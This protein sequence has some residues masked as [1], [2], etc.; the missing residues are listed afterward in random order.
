MVERSVKENLI[1]PAL[2]EIQQLAWRDGLAMKSPLLL[3]R[4]SLGLVPGTHMAA[5][6]I[7]KG[8]SG[9]PIS[10]SGSSR[11]YA[12]KHIHVGQTLMHIKINEALR[13]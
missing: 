13:I 8:T 10:S 5:Q 12:H 9:D 7:S 4:T 11:H 2:E 3:Q 6:T 1:Y